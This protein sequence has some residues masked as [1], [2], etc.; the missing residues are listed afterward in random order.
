VQSTAERKDTTIKIEIFV[1]YNISK[2]LMYGFIY[3]KNR[4]RNYLHCYINYMH[5]DKTAKYRRLGMMEHLSKFPLDVITLVSI[6]SQSYDT[7][8]PREFPATNR[9]VSEVSTLNAAH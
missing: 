9:L 8:G 7:L 2:N 4:D 6:N 3:L 1:G 5:V